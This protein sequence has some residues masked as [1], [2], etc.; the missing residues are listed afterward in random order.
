MTMRQAGG[1][2]VDAYLATNDDSPERDMQSYRWT[3]E[4]TLETDPHGIPP[5]ETA[6]EVEV[7]DVELWPVV[8]DRKG[9]A[10]RS[11]RPDPAAVE[12]A[13]RRSRAMRRYDVGELAEAPSHDEIAEVIAQGARHRGE[14]RALADARHQ[15]ELSQERAQIEHDAKVADA[16]R[17]HDNDVRAAQ[18][19]RERA[20]DP[21]TTLVRLT[22]AEK[23]LPGLGLVPA[24]FA[25][26]A[27][28]V[29]VFTELGRINP[30][31]WLVNWAVEPL[32]TWPLLVILLAQM[33]GA[34]P[35][36]DFSRGASAAFRTNRYVGMEV[37]LTLMAI[38]LNVVLHWLPAGHW[39]GDLVWLVVP[40]GLA[41]SAYLVPRLVTDIRQ[42]LR[43]WSDET[44]GGVEKPGANQG[45]STACD[46]HREKPQGRFSG[47]AE[48]R[49][50][51]PAR[52]GSKDR[53]RDEF[54]RLVNTGE[55]DPATETV[56]AIA[57][58]LNT[59]WENARDFVTEWRDDAASAA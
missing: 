12:A 5:I 42:A 33:L 53:A 46:L 35:K 7:D 24:V 27:G 38:V 49:P 43:E 41:F 13:V 57:K 58:R 1:D 34:L 18:R 29:N 14:R 32:F 31:T 45:F 19:R 17:Q 36:P 39:T 54:W 4:N 47:E 48:N 20:T 3:S 59:R 25:V 55:L 56:N 8:R 9:K 15:H 28:A 21:T 6:T 40:A 52:Y 51:N 16:E 30:E 50:D 37:G 2:V 44:T 23:W 10:V 26:A 11:Y 22:W